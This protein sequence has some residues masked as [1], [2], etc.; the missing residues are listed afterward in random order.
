MYSSVSGEKKVTCMVIQSAAF[1]IELQIVM[2]C[3]HICIHI[4]VF[5]G[6]KLSMTIF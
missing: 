4:P 1:Q 6:L 5:L 2:R 3:L